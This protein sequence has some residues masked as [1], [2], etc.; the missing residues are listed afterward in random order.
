MTDVDPVLIEVWRGDM[1]ESRHR[2]AYAVVDADGDV[3]AAQGDIERAVYA[4]S[5]I[6]PLQA[7]PLVESG[8]A[9]QLGL[10]G[11]EIA[12]ACA[13]HTGE[14]VH[15]AGV[16]DGGGRP[17]PL[18]FFQ[19]VPNAVA[20]HVAARWGL[21]GPVVCVGDADA[22]VDVDAVLIATPDHWH[23]PLTVSA[24]AAGKDVYV[25]KPL[26]HDLAEGQAVID[27]QNKHKRVVQ[28]GTQ[29]RSMTH[30]VQANDLLKK[31]TIGTVHKVHC[32][33]NRN[34]C[35][36]LRARKCRYTSRGRPAAT[37]TGRWSS[38]WAARARC[39]STAAGTR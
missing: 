17:G 38:S 14:P 12:L 28:V 13:S 33:W 36:G 15:V 31:G 27:A 35:C 30:I 20:G 23:V 5:A 3:I 25:E 32:T 22:G 4:R 2:G 19:A 10:T 24:C 29:Q 1:V 39:T 7:L 37:G 16:V 8:A 26:T 34:R 21:D 6:K 9:E 18:M 11:A